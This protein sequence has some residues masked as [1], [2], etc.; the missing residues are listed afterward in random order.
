MGSE[1]CIRDRTEPIGLTSGRNRW[2]STDTRRASSTAFTHHSQYVFADDP[3]VA[4]RAG[5][6]TEIDTDFTSKPPNH[7]TSWDLTTIW[8]G[9]NHGS[10]W[11]NRSRWNR[12]GC[13]GGWRCWSNRRRSWRSRFSRHGC[14][15]SWWRRRCGRWC[16]WLRS[17]RRRWCGGSGRFDFHQH[18]TGLYSITFGTANLCHCPSKLAGHNNRRLVRF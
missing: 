13:N 10:S 6:R 1:M 11:L 2:G 5:Y 9:G 14:G 16:G 4:T 7:W 12:S 17:R 3:S 8:N 15:S 18:V